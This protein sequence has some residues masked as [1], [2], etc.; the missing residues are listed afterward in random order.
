MA[1]PT[2]AEVATHPAGYALDSLR[3]LVAQTWNSGEN[4]TNMG[5]GGE[6]EG[7]S[8]GTKVRPDQGTYLML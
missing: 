8:R 5:L 4:R 3:V 7:V 1:R 2:D 6:G